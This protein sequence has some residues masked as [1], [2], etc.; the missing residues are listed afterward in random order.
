MMP[1][2]YE[3]YKGISLYV[4]EDMEDKT[5]FGVQF[6]WYGRLQEAQE[7]EYEEPT[8]VNKLN[9]ARSTI[10]LLLMLREQGHID[11]QG[12]LKDI[13]AALL[14]IQLSEGDDNGKR[15]I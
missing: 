7:E 2:P 10:D 9:A 14:E 3:V 15:E 12:D 13:S 6:D 5:K 8:L 4:W 11:N 1:P